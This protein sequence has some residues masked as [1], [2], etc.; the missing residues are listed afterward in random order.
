M[1][2]IPVLTNI[3]VMLSLLLLLP[4]VEPVNEVTLIP[5]TPLV[6]E[7]SIHHPKIDFKTSISGPILVT[8]S[9]VDL[10][11]EKLTTIVPNQEFT[12]HLSIEVDRNG[13]YVIEMTSALLGKVEIKGE[14]SNSM[15]LI[16]VGII[17]GVKAVVWMRDNIF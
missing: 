1:I 16:I 17:L 2:K 9:Y 8:I 7:I 10:F 6:I 5:D 14:G 4:Y 3:L 11:V 13:Y 15:N 12:G